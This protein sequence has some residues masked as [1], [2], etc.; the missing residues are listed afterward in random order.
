MKKI[1]IGSSTESKKKANVLKGILENLGASVTC[2][3]DI[4]SFALGDVTIDGLL[5]K[6]REY[7]AGVFV[8]GN[9]DKIVD[10]PETE[11]YIARDNVIAEAGIFVGAL[12]KD[13]VVL[14]YVPGTHKITDFNGVTYLEY[15]SDDQEQMKSRLNF[16]LKNKVRD[17]RPTRSENNLLLGPRELIHRKYTIANRLHLYD[18]GYR[19]VRKIRIMNIA[20]SLIIN[21]RFATNEHQEENSEKLSDAIQKILAEKHATLELMLLEPSDANLKD[22]VTKMANPSAGTLEGLVF[23]AWEMLYL[24]LT[25]PTVYSQAFDLKRFLCFSISVGIP[26]AI[27]NVEFDF[28]Y[29]QYDHVKIDL[30]S[31]EI[32]N[33]NERRSFVIWKDLDYENYMFFVRNFDAIRSNRNICHQVGLKE[34]EEWTDKWKCFQS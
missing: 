27:F 22:A 14:C 24:N 15:D 25:S 6:T 33:E 19:F 30:Y 9:D 3:Y 17:D 12:G 4:E 13:S 34:M 20:S 29:Q 18:D 10:A 5:A 26:Y 7:H 2:W 31:S 28:E 32:G 11:R 1:F 21:P 16:W 23:G 8:L